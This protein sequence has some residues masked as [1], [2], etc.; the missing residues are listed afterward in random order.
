[1]P[2]A[3]QR[4]IFL[5]YRRDDAGPYARSLQRDLSQRFPAAR[6][7][8]DLDS[9][10]PGLDFAEVIEEAVNS[11]AVLLALIGRQ[12]VTLTGEDGERRLDNPDDY[13]RFEV[14]AAL[15]RGV[16]VIPVLIDGARPLRRQ[17]LPEELHRLA[18]LNAAKLSYDRYQEDTDRL[19]D[20]IQR[21]LEGAPRQ[22]AGDQPSLATG[23]DASLVSHPEVAQPDEFVPGVVMPDAN[24]WVLLSAADLRLVGEGA[25]RFAS[26]DEKLPINAVRL[27]SAP[28][29]LTVAATDRFRMDWHCLSA[30][31]RGSES[32]TALVRAD[33]FSA[34]RRL[35]PAGIV[36]LIAHKEEVIFSAGER[37]LSMPRLSGEFPNLDVF[38]EP[39]GS[40]FSVQRLALIDAVKSV[41]ESQRAAPDKTITLKMPE[42]SDL[43]LYITVLG[44]H[45]GPRLGV[46]ADGPVGDLSVDINPRYVLECLDTFTEDRVVI[47]VTT[48]HKPLY[49]LNAKDNPTHRHIIMPVKRPA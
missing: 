18:R 5:S 2:G 29:G 12:W 49:F 4:G 28:S 22:S 37:S 23:T 44:N 26:R 25:P 8:M 43:M 10:E 3:P 48:N 47:S 40:A 11:S 13:V 34:L 24:E 6:I 33:D 20:L 21:V 27:V 31:S 14:T 16:R 36:Y 42:S 15:E 38:I 35:P 9:I 41:T 32:F 7:F 45:G 17:D 39:K 30:K 1:M 46:G 19:L